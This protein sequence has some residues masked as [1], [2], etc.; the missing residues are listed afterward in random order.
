[1]P[2]CP[3]CRIRPGAYTAERRY[4]LVGSPLLLKSTPLA[5]T[6]ELK[7]ALHSMRS[8]GL[9]GRTAPAAAFVNRPVAPSPMA[10]AAPPIPTRRGDPKITPSCTSMVKFRSVIGCRSGGGA[11][12]GA[13][14]E[15]GAG[16][17]RTNAP[18]ARRR[19]ADVMA[20]TNHQGPWGHKL[21]T[22]VV[23]SRA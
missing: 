15:A 21:G 13:G 12:A 2:H 23:G 9:V 3:T 10:N 5:G 7:K 16:A 6:Y 22:T 8:V 1:M 19:P 18:A 20:T 11:W 17:V 14:G 4:W